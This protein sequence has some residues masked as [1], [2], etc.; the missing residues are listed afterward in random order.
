MDI[1]T[2]LSITPIYIALLGL[3]FVPI[4]LRVGIY[5]VNNKISLGDGGDK[6]LLKRMRAQ[7]NFIET[8]PLV[9]IM[10]VLMELAGAPSAWLH[11]VGG[12]LLAGRLLHYI[13]LTGIGSFVCRPIGIFATLGTYLAA[14][15]WLLYRF[16]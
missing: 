14:A 12:T 3:F 11:G 7:A 2:V 6:E 15:G 8:V 16:L 10:L 13:G 5:R 1:P 4:T 9:V